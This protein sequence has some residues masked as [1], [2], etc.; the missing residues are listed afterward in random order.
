MGSFRQGEPPVDD[1]GG[2]EFY[3]HQVRTYDGKTVNELYEEGNWPPVVEEPQSTFGNAKRP[4][5]SAKEKR[6]LA[7]ANAHSQEV[8]NPTTRHWSD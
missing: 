6:N 5:L 8:L 4:E 1:I 3:E 2:V 7:M